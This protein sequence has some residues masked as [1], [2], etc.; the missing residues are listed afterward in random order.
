M[1]EPKTE[2]RRPHPSARRQATTSL[3]RLTRPFRDIPGLWWP[4]NGFLPTD[5]GSISRLSPQ[6]FGITR[7]NPDTPP[8][9][10]PR[11]VRISNTACWVFTRRETR[12]TQHGFSL[13]LRRLQGEQPQARTTGFSRITSH[14][15]RLLW[16]FWS[17]GVRKGGA[18]RKR[19]PDRSARRQAAASLLTSARY[20]ALLRGKKLLL[21]QCPRPVS[22]FCVGLTENAK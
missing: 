14:E 16:S 15:T 2:I 5:N 22:Q 6:F 3:R 18:A 21:S 7:Y 19:R 20:C 12:I 17:P 11:A 4:D 1:A 8:S 13:S 9:R 10:C